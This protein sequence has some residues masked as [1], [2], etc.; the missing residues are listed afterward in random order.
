MKD[1]VEPF[2]PRAAAYARREALDA[3]IEWVSG[4]GYHPCGTV[5]MGEAV[6][7]RGRID[8]MENLS[9]C[10]ASL[11]PTIP[12]ANTH[13]SVLMMGERFAEWVE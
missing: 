5:P 11:M 10:D 6:D 4:S 12:S 2:F 13:L 9:I 1:M 7:Q 8:G 3:A